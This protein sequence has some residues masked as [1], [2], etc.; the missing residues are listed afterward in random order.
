MGYSSWGLPLVLS[1]KGEM[2][3][4]DLCPT[5]RPVTPCPGAAPEHATK[6]QGKA[7]GRLWDA[8]CL[9]TPLC[10]L[11]SWWHKPAES[12]AVFSS[13]QPTGTYPKRPSTHLEFL[14]LRILSRSQAEQGRFQA[15]ARSRQ[16]PVPGGCTSGGLRATQRGQGQVCASTCAPTAN[17][18]FPPPPPERNRD[19]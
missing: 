12:P 18:V 15:D 3:R 13:A 2:S 5:H 9:C 6:L 8:L 7:H 19:V 10:T 14:R 16:D 1:H 17:S 4:T 11:L